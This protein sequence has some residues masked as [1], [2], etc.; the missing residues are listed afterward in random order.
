MDDKLADLAVRQSLPLLPVQLARLASLSPP[1]VTCADLLL[2]S[3]FDLMEQCDW[4]LVTARTILKAVARLRAP[5][6]LTVAAQAGSG[7]T[8]LCHTLAVL[9]A[10]DNGDGGLHGDV[11]Y[12]DTERTFRAD[13]LVEIAQHRFPELADD[14]ARLR[15]VTNRVHVAVVRSADELLTR[16]RDRGT[17]AL[18]IPRRL[19]T[20][21]TF[22]EQ[23]RVC[24]VIIDSAAALVRH[25]LILVT[26]QV[27]TRFQPP[28][29]LGLERQHLDQD[30]YH[31]AALGNTWS[32]A[33]TT[34]IELRRLSSIVRRDG[35]A[36][37]RQLSVVKSPLAPVCSFRYAITSAGFVE[38]QAL[39][40]A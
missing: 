8:Q 1:V 4:D 39:T 11:V 33:I 27:A 12:F 40:D 30:G 15:R 20:L 10:H 14:P 19:S 2:L 35:A 22:I 38:E 37:S 26:N 3:E 34:R 24:L 23:K 25:E 13:R 17:H 21:T 7:K 9:A 29:I 18:S 32:H 28:S 36:A 31:V 16:H 5:K 6:S